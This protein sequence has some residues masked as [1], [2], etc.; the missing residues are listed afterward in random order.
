MLSRFVVAVLSLNVLAGAC[1]VQ[2][3]TAEEPAVAQ[4]ELRAAVGKSLPL[5]MK[6]AVGHREER[7]QCFA[8]HQQ[9]VP[10]F[11]LT[12]AKTKGFAIDDA[13]LATQLQFIADFLAK[14]R[15][16]Y[17]QGKGTGGQ[18][19]TAG[20]ALVT[21][22]AGGW[23]PDA[24]TAAVSEYLL[25]RHKDENHWKSTSNRPPTEASPFTTSY[26]ALRGL[27]DFGTPEQKERTGKR[28]E[29]VRE[30][31]VG[32]AAKDNEDRVFRLLG[33][34]L[35]NAPEEDIAA[36]AKDLLAKQRDD[37]GWAQ[38]DSY[39]SEQ[40][41]PEGATKSD[42]YAT[43]TA[44]VAL[45]Q[46]GGLATTDAAYQRGLS[47]LLK[48]QQPDGSWHVAS[49][50]KPFQAYYESGFPHGNDQFIS[51]AASG[52]ATWALVLACE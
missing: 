49:R 41:Q 28:T 35:A 37:G 32:A 36:A 11:A 48:T 51:C 5:L 18:A 43:G 29:Q 20:Y 31:L 27:A 21:L 22:A 52:W 6:A 10:I 24:T 50:S 13:E 7:K 23:Q 9:G 42:A 25:L 44:L 4:D 15:E 3:V 26:V 39:D 45:H 38:L 34:K 2:L 19:D 47:Y 14:N 8:C 30:W 1:L 40:G 12:A 17:L 46:A 33:L 16:N